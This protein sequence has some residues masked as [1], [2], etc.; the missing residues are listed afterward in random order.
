[1]RP[2]NHLVDHRPI[3]K[4]SKTTKNEMNDAQMFDNLGSIINKLNQIII[5]HKIAKFIFKTL[6]NLSV[7]QLLSDGSYPIVTFVI[8]F[9]DIIR[10]GSNYD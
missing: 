4:T 2:L 7:L 8:Q 10:Q 3:G 9:S 6:W 1:M 5:N